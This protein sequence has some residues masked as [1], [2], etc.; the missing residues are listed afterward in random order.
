MSDLI[1]FLPLLITF[2]VFPVLAWLCLRWL[3]PG[4]RAAGLAAAGLLLLP[5]L[6]I[7]A[8]DTAVRMHDV[9]HFL[10]A[11]LP[12]I[13]SYVLLFIIHWVLVRIWGASEGP[14][15]MV[16][17]FFP[18][19]L[20]AIAKYAPGH[21]GEFY[22]GKRFNV[23]YLGLSYVTFRLGLLALEVRNR[24]VPCPSLAEYLGFTFMPL[25]LS[26]GPISAYSLFW[27]SLSKPVAPP[28]PV[29]L[30]RFLKGATKYLLLGNLV[31]QLTYA[32][33]LGDGHPHPPVDVIVAILAYYLYLYLNFSGYCD[34]VVATAACCGIEIQENFDAPFTARNL[35]D[36][37]K[38]WHM[39]LGIYLRDLVFSPLSKFIATKQGGRNIQ[40]AVA[41]S[42]FCVF[43][44][45]GVWHGVGWNFALYGAVHG[46]GVVTVHYYTQFLRKK[47][48]RK[49]YQDYMANRFIKGAGIVLTQSFAALSLILFANPLPAVGRLLH[50]VIDW[51][52]YVH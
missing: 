28:I 25:T 21:W 29:V 36:F 26:V 41:I 13:A 37:W 42:I 7:L 10:A 52:P 23:L 33:L 48:S 20:L 2:G 46:V 22:P 51:V 19:A 3:S 35:Q 14:S 43:L 16:P 5:P 32:G 40:H 12:L 11:A 17:I 15:G 4:R 34:M 30:P 18:L 6:C 1:R 8:S 45:I 39:T 38:R 50:S 9:R 27:R 24:V 49:A 47:L 31:N 44:V